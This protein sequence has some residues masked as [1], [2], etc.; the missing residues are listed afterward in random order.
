MR[1]FDRLSLPIT[2]LHIN[3]IMSCVRV[4]GWGIDEINK[5][6]GENNIFGWFYIKSDTLNMPIP[7]YYFYNAFIQMP[8]FGIYKSVY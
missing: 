7:S 2:F 5:T 3:N 4:D 8:I 1:D 6:S